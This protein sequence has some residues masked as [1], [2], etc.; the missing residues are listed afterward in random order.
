MSIENNIEDFKNSINEAL[1]DIDILLKS[2]PSFNQRIIN[3]IRDIDYNLWDCRNS[4]ERDINFL[5]A[6]QID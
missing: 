1:N 2:N 3:E 4:L 6:L 5:K